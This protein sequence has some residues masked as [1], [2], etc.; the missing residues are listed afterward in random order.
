[1]AM[2]KGEVQMI[3][4]DRL[5]TDGGTQPRAGSLDPAVVADYGATIEGMDDLP[6]MEAVKDA[7]GTLWL[8]DGFHRKAAYE[9]QEIIL[10]AVRVRDGTLEEARW[11]AC[12]ANARHGL[13][14]TD[15]DKRRAAEMALALHPEMSNRQLADHCAVSEGLV[16]S[17][18]ESTAH[19]AQLRTG[20]D[21][22]TRKMPQK[23]E[24]AAPSPEEEAAEQ[25]EAERVAKEWAGSPLHPP[26]TE[27]DN[28]AHKASQPMVD[29][30][31]QAVPEAFAVAYG[32]GTA[33]EQLLSALRACEREV[34]RL[35]KSG[36]A[37][38]LR[39][40]CRQKGD[41]QGSEQWL[42]E[43]LRSAVTAVRLSI[44]YTICPHCWDALPGVASA[45]CA[46]CCGSGVV[47]KDAFER[48]HES[49]RH[50]VEHREK[51]AQAEAQA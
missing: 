45:D 32:G 9:A 10:A 13:R 11:L 44:P 39:K 8:W 2:A 23:P 15:A 40:A 16:R 37:P 4:L 17:A 1:M 18:R 31:G 35:C 6:P 14:R 3:R 24:P 28:E 19:N 7:D 34:T 30:F 43:P 42:L 21:G 46:A 27:A 22:K 38:H 26:A 20:K 48:T 33:L 50:A 5:R 51:I 25:A 49:L 12:G 41:G 36:A 29:E 47:P